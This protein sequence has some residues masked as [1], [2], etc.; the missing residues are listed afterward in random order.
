MTLAQNA[1][2]R[3]RTGAEAGDDPAFVQT[4]AGHTYASVTSVYTSLGDDFKQK[5]IARRVARPEEV[6]PDG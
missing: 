1:S 2:D 3:T 5:M 4:Q 6:N